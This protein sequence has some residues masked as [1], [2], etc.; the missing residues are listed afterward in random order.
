MV[1]LLDDF[2]N[3]QTIK[4]STSFKLSAASHIAS[5]VLDVQ[6]IHAILKKP[7]QQA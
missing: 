5:N 1:Q 7:R 6:N 4:R 3:I 2:P